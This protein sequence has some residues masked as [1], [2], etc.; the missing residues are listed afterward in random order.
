MIVE[1]AGTPPALPAFPGL[2]STSSTGN[3]LELVMVNFGP[4]QQHL[5]E[6]LN[7]LTCDV[8][9]M[10]LEDAFVAFTR[11]PKPPLPAFDQEPGPA[12]EAT[13]DKGAA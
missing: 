5:I 3:R 4:D 10:G 12:H 6:S 11:G 1:F 9:E 2:V 13:A 7:P 8:V